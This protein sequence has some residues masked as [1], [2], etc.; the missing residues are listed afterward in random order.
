MPLPP[1]P[2]NKMPA[3]TR[4]LDEHMYRQAKIWCLQQ[5]YIYMNGSHDTCVYRFTCRCCRLLPIGIFSHE[6]RR[7]SFTQFHLP[8]QQPIQPYS[9]Q[10]KHSL[11]INSIAHLICRRHNVTSNTGRKLC[12]H[13]S[14]WTADTRIKIGPIKY[15]IVLDYLQWIS[16]LSTSVSGCV[17]RSTVRKKGKYFTLRPT[18]YR[19]SKS[20]NFRTQC[21]Y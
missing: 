9:T 4:I 17:Y 16:H 10:W 13:L 12:I 19:R 15:I 6:L 2:P 8:R 3:T 1:P 21:T 7:M 14:A 18:D 11:A 20:H 5:T